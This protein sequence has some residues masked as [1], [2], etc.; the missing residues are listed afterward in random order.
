MGPPPGRTRVCVASGRTLCPAGRNRRGSYGCAFRAQTD[1]AE[2][3]GLYTVLSRIAP[4]SV[5]RLNRAI[6]VSM[7]HGPQAALD[8]IAP[9]TGSEDLAAYDLAHAAEADMLRQ[10]NRM[11]EALVAYWRALGLCRLEPERRVLLRR[12]AELEDK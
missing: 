1:W 5:V 12:I 11:P 6:A 8:L 3:L 9:L 2:I 10:L 4:S 7:V